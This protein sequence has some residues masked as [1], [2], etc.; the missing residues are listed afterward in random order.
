LK[1][2]EITISPTGQ[3]SVETKGFSGSECRQASQFI[4]AALGQRT[5]ERLTSDFYAQESQPQRLQE[6]A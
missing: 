2:I 6:G 4:E 5:D 3:T 1:T